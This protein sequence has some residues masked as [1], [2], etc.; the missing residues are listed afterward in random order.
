MLTPVLLVQVSVSAS[1]C[2]DEKLT[3][4]EPT[5][6]DLLT[7]MLIRPS[8]IA[9][10]I[11]QAVRANS[12]GHTFSLCLVDSD[13]QKISTSTTVN[14]R[15]TKSWR[16]YLVDLD[17]YWRTARTLYS[18]AM[19]AT[20]SGYFRTNLDDACDIAEACRRDVGST[21]I[22]QGV[23]VTVS[24]GVAQY[25]LWESAEGSLSRAEQALHLAKQFGRDRVEVASSPASSAQA[26]NVI[27][28]A[29][30]V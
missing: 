12:T 17:G 8:F 28:L 15:V 29:R 22:Q 6:F 30:S 27:P 18:A 1:L 2:N 14:R 25:R 13:Q 16:K 10:L 20:A 9:E 19:T 26:A 23:R 3:P 21:D 5:E 7:G 11:E 4:V 24:A